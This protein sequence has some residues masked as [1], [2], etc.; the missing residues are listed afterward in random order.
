MTS[1]EKNG[2]EE[3]GKGEKGKGR[4]KKRREKKRLTRGGTAL[5]PR[6]LRRCSSGGL[7][8]QV[9]IVFSSFSSS[10][11][12]SPSLGA[13]IRDRFNASAPNHENS[14]ELNSRDSRASNNG[15]MEAVI[16]NRWLDYVGADS[17]SL[18]LRKENRNRGLNAQR[19]R[20]DV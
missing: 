14:I 2:G 6:T 3:E 19:T 9:T 13:F 1:G 7:F 5:Q 12:P 11:P 4:R 18:Q 20:A 15:A 17:A 10:F 16:S 8:L